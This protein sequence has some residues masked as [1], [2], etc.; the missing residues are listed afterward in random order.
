MSATYSGKSSKR[1]ATVIVNLVT[2]QIAHVLVKEHHT[3]AVSPLLPPESIEESG[4][5]QI[6][7]RRTW[8]EPEHIEPPVETEFVEIQFPYIHL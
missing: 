3:P 7:P 8:A 5:A 4:Q 1:P 2:E 6:H